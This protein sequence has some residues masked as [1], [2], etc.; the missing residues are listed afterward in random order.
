MVL[1][2]ILGSINGNRDTGCFE[3]FSDDVRPPENEEEKRIWNSKLDDCELL[4][5]SDGEEIS[6]RDAKLFSF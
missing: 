2:I 4:L 5:C 6:G 3:E 1:S